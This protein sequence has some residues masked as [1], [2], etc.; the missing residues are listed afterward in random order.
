[1]GTPCPPWP[2]VPYFLAATLAVVVASV[3]AAQSH[4]RFA[5]GYVLYS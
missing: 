3:V 4:N 1:M 2:I 5:V